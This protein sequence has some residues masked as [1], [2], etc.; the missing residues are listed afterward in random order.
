MVIWLVGM[1]GA[2]KSTIG[3]CLYANLKKDK[4]GTVFVDGDEIRSL[5]NH[6]QV[7]GAY[8][9][10]GRK[11]N[12]Q[13]IQS[14]CR[15]LDAQG[16]DVVCCILSIFQDISDENRKT[17]SEYREV[18]I[19]VPLSVL[20]ERDNKGIY[21]AALC[22]HQC[23]VVGVDIEYSPPAAPDLVISNS[24]EELLLPEY[25]NSIINLCERGIK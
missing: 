24:F 15:W 19:D 1:S 23:N 13:R 9:L 21:Q 2:G 3:R 17:F 12:A 7:D 16:L 18:F 11:I 20:M 8:T 5:F 4:P 14:I 22:G 10:A 6:D 25:V